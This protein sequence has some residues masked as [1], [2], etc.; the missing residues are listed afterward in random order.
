M[1]HGVADG[2][3]QLQGPRAREVVGVCEKADVVHAHHHWNAR[4]GGG[5]ILHVQQVG[6]IAQQAARQIESQSDEWVHRYLPHGETAGDFVARGRSR[7]VGDELGPITAHRKSLQEITDIGFI[8]G[9]VLS[10][11]VGVNGKSHAPTN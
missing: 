9:E 1:L 2:E 8:T 3:V 5:R 10:N 7:Y 11:R 4:E 6:A